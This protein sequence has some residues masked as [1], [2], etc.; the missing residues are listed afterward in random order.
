MTVRLDLNGQTFKFR[1]E[2]MLGTEYVEE[3]LRHAP[4]LEVPL[5]RQFGYDVH[6][7]ARAVAHR[8]SYLIEGKEERRLDE[9]QWAK[10]FPLLDAGSLAK[11]T[12]TVFELNEFASSRAVAAAKKVLDGTALS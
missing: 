9:E 5:H 10:M 1:F 6:A 7:M 2:Q 8:C 11:I 4:D 12:N 3:T